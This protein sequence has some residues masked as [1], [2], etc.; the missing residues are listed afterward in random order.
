MTGI[1]K[2][3]TG[4][5]KGATGLMET[6]C[7]FELIV[8]STVRNIA[9]EETSTRNEWRVVGWGKSGWYN[10]NREEEKKRKSPL[11]MKIRDV[12]YPVL[13]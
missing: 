10:R 2:G 1:R 3:V 7:I 13:A 5:R 9:G 8:N 4:A 12:F 11:S 6:E